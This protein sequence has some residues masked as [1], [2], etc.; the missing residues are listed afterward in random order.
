MVT[1]KEFCSIFDYS[2]PFK[3]GAAHI[4]KKSFNQEYRSVFSYQAITISDEDFEI[5]R[6][7]K[8]TSLIVR[9][10]ITCILYMLAVLLFPISV[11][12]C[13]KKI[14]A[15]ERLVLLRLGK[16]Q[17]VRGPGFAIILPCIDKWVKVD[18]KPKGFTISL[19]QSL[20]A[21][22]AIVEVKSDIEY[23][24]SDVINYVMK[25][26]QQE[27]TLKDLSQFCLGNII[28]EKDQD[29]LELKREIINFSFKNELNRS[30]LKWGLE[31]INVNLHSIKVLKAAEPIDAIGT[32]M[33][34]LKAATGQS[35]DASPPMFPFIP[36]TTATENNSDISEAESATSA[37]SSHQ[38]I[39][40]SDD[41]L[42]I[43]K[44][45]TNNVYQEGKLTN[46]IAKFQLDI[47][48]DSVRKVYLCFDK[49]NF[50]IFE[51]DNCTIVCDV[52]IELTEHVLRE[53]LNGKLS[54][55]NA[56]MDGKVT[57]TGDWKLLKYLALIFQ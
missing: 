36:N 38:D 44:C 43:L 14:H 51:D 45:V 22:R 7:E 35:S 1:E 13:L 34:A 16:L 41:I 3:Y 30:A 4:K 50:S 47:L 55:L 17:P 33:T 28:S 53:F 21:D 52:Y 57:V 18:L 32:L 20:T 24:I 19:S 39:S 10:T 54:P 56:Y 25:L 23:R 11:F 49:D 9:Y 26:R 40:N 42:D 2:S 31:I 37:S 12:I 48:G 6:K 29:D 15:L 27:S 8:W 5:D 46:L